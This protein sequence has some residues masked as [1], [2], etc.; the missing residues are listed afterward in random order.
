MEYKFG[1][2]VEQIM[3][4]E[5]HGCDICEMQKVANEQNEILREIASNLRTL[6]LIEIE[7]ETAYKR[8][9]E[10]ARLE[11]IKKGVYHLS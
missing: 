1:E 9:S 10:V 3:R 5:N 4:C 6:I 7:R 2:R 8:V 11:C